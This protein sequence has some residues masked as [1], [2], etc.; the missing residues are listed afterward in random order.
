MAILFFW[1]LLGPKKSVA[2]QIPIGHM[3]M[4]LETPPNSWPVISS[5]VSN[6]FDLGH[7]LIN[8]VSL[9]TNMYVS[10]FLAAQANFVNDNLCSVQD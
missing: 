7:P 8:W 1:V 6:S 5:C 3:G 9:L 2:Q 4:D 10:K